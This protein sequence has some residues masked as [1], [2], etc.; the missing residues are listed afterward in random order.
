[1]TDEPD[2]LREG[3]EEAMAYVRSTERLLAALAQVHRVAQDL[4]ELVELDA[5]LLPEA[6][7]AV[8]HLRETTEAIVRGKKSLDARFA[9]KW[10]TGGTAHTDTEGSG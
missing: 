10:G 6:S 7:A 5:F 2:P 1:M 4:T 3:I 8:T 9:V